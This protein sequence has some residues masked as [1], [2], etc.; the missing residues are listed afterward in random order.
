MKK[1][2][3]LLVAFVFLQTQTWALSGGPQYTSGGVGAASIGTYAGVLIPK[4]TNRLY[5]NPSFIANADA[6]DANTLGIFVL[7]VPEQ[8]VAT[9]NYLFFQDGEAFFGAIQGVV[10]PDGD[11]FSALLSGAAATNNG[12]TTGTVE[13]FS[14]ISA[15]GKLE[16]KL[17]VPSSIG[18]SLRL[19]GEAFVQLQGYA[20]DSSPS[21]AG[22]TTLRE[23]TFEV[24]GFKQSNQAGTPTIAPPN[25]TSVSPPTTTLVP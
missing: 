9:G 8:G 7:G 2:L 20:P 4:F 17:E 13:Y 6:T 10:D 11:K 21:G 12:D 14:P 16:A 5:D 1:V 24:D 3:S 15:V 25:T 18:A 23:I 19:Q 22:F